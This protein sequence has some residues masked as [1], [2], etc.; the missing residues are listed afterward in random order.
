MD[1]VAFVATSFA[2]H[3]NSRQLQSTVDRIAGARRSRVVRC[4][5]V[6][7]IRKAGHHRQKCLPMGEHGLVKENPC[8]SD[9]NAEHAL[10]ANLLTTAF[11]EHLAE[12]EVDLPVRMVPTTYSYSLCASLTDYQTALLPSSRLLTPNTSG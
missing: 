11:A 2:N 12:A 9:P 5:L 4:T 6:H 1:L 7:F 10:R 3:N 8:P